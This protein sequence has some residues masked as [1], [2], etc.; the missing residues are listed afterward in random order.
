MRKAK[1][2]LLDAAE[3]LFVE[4]GFAAT[5]LR[6]IT[7]V[8]EVNLASVNYYFRTKQAL[9]QEILIR[10]LRPINQRRLEM[11]EAAEAA[12]CGLPV[13]VERLVEAF[14]LPLLDPEQE[15][16]QR[17]IA[18]V[19]AEPAACVQSV[20]VAECSGILQ[21]FASALQ[22]AL[23]HLSTNYI[24]LRLQFAIGVLVQ[25]FAGIQFQKTSSSEGAGTDLLR[26]MVLFITAGMMAPTTACVAPG[27][28]PG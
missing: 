18:R 19:H 27:K 5:S 21:R 25:T 6:A 26:Q 3:Q 8:A 22:R 12:T 7:A 16:L 14:V 23:P 2:R 15:R 13:P 24:N 20:F 17:L 9:F 28:S 10:R 4:K 1:I 11:L